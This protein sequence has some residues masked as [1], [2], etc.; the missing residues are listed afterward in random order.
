MWNNLKYILSKLQR[1]RWK[2]VAFCSFC[3]LRSGSRHKLEAPYAGTQIIRLN[4][5]LEQNQILNQLEMQH[6]ICSVSDRIQVSFQDILPFFGDKFFCE[7][8]LWL[9][10]SSL[11]IENRN[12]KCWAINYLPTPRPLPRCFDVTRMGIEDGTE[13][14][15]S[16]CYKLTFD[17]GSS[18]HRYQSVGVVCKEHLKFCWTA[19]M[20]MI[21][22]RAQCRW[23]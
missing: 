16:I 17:I 8:L 12:P 10:Y 7:F 22:M 4:Q 21:I 3:S 2:K 18:W 23:W 19:A 5:L 6:N 11:D 14:E 15:V 20:Q 1:K 13:R 9:L